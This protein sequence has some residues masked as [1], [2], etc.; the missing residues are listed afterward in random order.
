MKLTVTTFLTLDGVM[1]GPGGADEDRSD[2]FELGGWLPAFMDPAAGT[3]VAEWFA[4]ADAF[5]L[6]RRT[7]ETF[8]AFWPRVTDPGDPVA[9]RLNGRPK[10]VVTRTL[11]ATTWTGT[12]LVTDDLATAVGAIKAMPGDEGQV[13]GSGTLVRSLHDLG[14][15]DEYR[16]WTFPVVVGQ[17]RRLFTG[18]LVPR[19]FELGTEV[20]ID[21]TGTRSPFDE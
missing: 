6:G 15:T 12:E 8:A 11:T 20:I 2:G 18:G 7:F 21:E 14:L 5:L 13:H 16:L 19:S 17:G 4:R 3:F 1:Q 9:S 10:F